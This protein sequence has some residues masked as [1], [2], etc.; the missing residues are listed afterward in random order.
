MH[1]FVI[2]LL[3]LPLPAF[4][5]NLATYSANSGSLPPEHAWDVIVTIAADGQLVLKRC[6]GYETEGPACTTRMAKVDGA[7]LT[8]IKVA[9]PDEFSD[10]ITKGN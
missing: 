2:C 5:Q 8:T 9:I 7:K 1:R 6:A 4:A 10:L 3:C